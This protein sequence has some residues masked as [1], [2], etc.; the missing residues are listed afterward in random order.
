MPDRPERSDARHGEP[1]W[2]KP[3]FEVTPLAELEDQPGFDRD[4]DRSS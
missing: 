1:A 2:E 3:D 4:D